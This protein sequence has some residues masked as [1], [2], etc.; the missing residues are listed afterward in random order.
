VSTGY[1]A[2]LLEITPAGTVVKTYGGPN[3][4][5]A[6]LIKP[7]FYNSFQVLNNGHIVITNWQGHGAGHGGV[8]IQLMEY[9]S[10]GAMVWYWKDSTKY[11][12]L[13]TVIVLDSLNTQYLHDDRYGGV[14]KPVPPPSSV[15]VSETGYTING[16]PK[17]L[18]HANER[19]FDLLG[20][21]VTGRNGSGQGM[22]S[23]SHELCIQKSG[24]PTDRCSILLQMRNP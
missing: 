23:I 6:A 16:I 17:M 15:T 14:L 8:G 11:S 5:Q 18:P 1:G 22:M 10:S 13:H 4:A 19:L 12:S 20:R 2:T 24:T 7:Y 3:Q 21:E 9:D